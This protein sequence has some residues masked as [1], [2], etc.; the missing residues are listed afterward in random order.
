MKATS[1]TTRA[2]SRRIM[3]LVLSLMAMAALASRSQA[4]QE[5]KQ[6]PFS[7][8]FTT[9]FENVV[10]FPI[11]H[12]TVIGEGKATHLGKATAS[13][14]NQLVNLLTGESTAT[15]TFTAAN[16]DTLVLEM[17][18]QSTFDQIP[19]PECDVRGHLQC[20]GR[21]WPIFRG[22]GQWDVDRLGCIYGAEQRR[23]LVHC[24]RH[25]LV[26]RQFE[27]MSLRT[28]GVK[29]IICAVQ[30]RASRFHF[31]LSASAVNRGL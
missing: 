2:M 18:F 30:R 9:E 25:D 12:V 31:G 5:D 24:D 26:T 22:D 15:Y 3:R 27:V 11:A 7:A 17:D 6:V 4:A 10:M 1:S 23:G 16:G 13:T 19:P 21:N 20:D 28:I 14:D 29:K 8:A